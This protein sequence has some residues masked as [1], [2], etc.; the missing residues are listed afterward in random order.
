MKNNRYV[1][2]YLPVLKALKHSEGPYKWNVGINITMVHN[3]QVN[4]MDTQQ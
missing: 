3:V 2:H 4:S 1:I